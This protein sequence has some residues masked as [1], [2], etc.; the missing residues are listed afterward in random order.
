MLGVVT[1]DQLMIEV[2]DDVEVGDEAVLIGAQ[3]Q[4]EIKA[5]EIGERLGTIG[6]EVLTSIGPRVRRVYAD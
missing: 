2:D 4:H 3:G 6:Y 1:M 5:N